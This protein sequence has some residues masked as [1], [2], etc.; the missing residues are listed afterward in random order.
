MLWCLFVWVARQAWA[1]AGMVL[2]YLLCS[3]M[4]VINAA[5]LPKSHFNANI[6][7]LRQR[8]KRTQDEMAAA[9]DMKRSTLS[10]Y[11]NGVAQPSIEVLLAMSAYFKMSIDTLIKLDMPRL[12]E[13]QLVD[14][15]LGYDPYIRGSQL[16]VL[17]TTIDQQA[18]ENIELVPE[19]A[20]AGYATGFAD[21]EFVA[22]LP[23]FQM[24]FLHKERNYRCFQI[25]GDSMLPIP[26]K[27]YVI[28]EFV[29]DWHEI[30]TGTPCIL[31]TMEDGIVFKVVDNLLQQDRTF[32]LRSLNPQYQP[33]SVAAADV[34][35]IWKFTHFIQDELPDPQMAS[36]DIVNYLMK[37]QEEV[38]LVKKAVVK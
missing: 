34:K 33:Y 26:D 17:S 1:A 35:E 6:K 15:E 28:G 13:R 29:L 21:P 16:R 9:L 31:L 36:G 10:G 30:K 32:L 25:S 38:G 8:K 37:L 4:A 18:R 19:R 11:E 2:L 23:K 12:S 20:K 7:F 27:A 14:M 22:T 24:P 3:A 5:D